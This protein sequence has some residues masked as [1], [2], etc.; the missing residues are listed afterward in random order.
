MPSFDVNSFIQT[1]DSI[2]GGVTKTLGTIGDS[3]NTF[4]NSAA[5]FL[6]GATDPAGFMKNILGRNIPLGAE[7]T[8]STVA[9]DVAVQTE[10]NFDWR[11]SL[12]VPST[13]AGS[14]VFEPFKQTDNKLIFPYTPTINVTH[15]AMYNDL[16][17]VHNN[18]PFLSYA[19]SK[20]D[21]IQIDAPFFVEDLYE[22]FYWLAVLHYFKSVTKMAY[23][24]SAFQGTP[25]PV[26]RL[27]GYGT[28]VFNNIPVVVESFQMNLAN[29]TDY[30]TAGQNKVPI[31]SNFVITLKPIYS[32]EEIR[33][34]SLAKF[35]NGGYL[36]DGGYM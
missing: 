30:M 21:S 20:I 32:R 28:D 6:T 27:N 22:G 26:V 9:P 19:G 8:S 10:G 18:Y 16:T 7:T 17:P 33:K 36:G 1:K 12:S 35:I 29:D 2:V 15:Q 34:F 3:V 4:K 14:F 5:N 31:K 13:F 11:V 24:E 25:P 23:G